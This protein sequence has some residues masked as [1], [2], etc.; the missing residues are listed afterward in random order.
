MGKKSIVIVYESVGKDEIIVNIL[1]ENK[2][3]NFSFGLCEFENE[4]EYLGYKTKL[5]DMEGKSGFLFDKN[6]NK[7]M[8]EREIKRFASHYSII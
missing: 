3:E 4:M 1:V 7:E 2:N 6:I 8:L 5:V